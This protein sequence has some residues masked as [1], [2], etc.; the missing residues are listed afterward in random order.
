[1]HV[2]GSTTSPPSASTLTQGELADMLGFVTDVWEET[3]YPTFLCPTDVFVVIM[4]INHLRSQLLNFA[5]SEADASPEDLLARLKAFSPEA[6]AATKTSS[7]EGWLL[8]ARAHHSAAILYCI[9]TLE[10]HF[11]R[12]SLQELEILRAVHAST[13]FSVLRQ[14]DTIPGVRMGSL[15]P[16][17]VAGVEAAREDSSTRSFVG[18]RFVGLADDLATP[19]MLEAKEVFE[20]FWVSGKVG[21]EKC[22][23]R[24]Y[25]FVL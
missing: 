17:V 24:P 1:M 12:S 18:K 4:R 14:S 10:K 7:H 22:F 25:A 21:W 19:L 16:L 8:V 20:R 13:L 3:P 2:T 11:P 5:L 9:S 15:W 23:D 6:W